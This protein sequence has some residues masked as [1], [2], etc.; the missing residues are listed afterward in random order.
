[1]KMHG[2]IIS[3]PKPEVIVIPKGGVD[4]VFKAAAILDYAEFDK[5][6]PVPN[7]PEIVRP[8]GQK[9]IDLEDKT[10]NNQ[11]TAW[12]VKKNA[13]MV[14]TSL[15][16]TEGL[17]WETV[18]AGDPETWPN[19]LTELRKVFTDAENDAIYRTVLT[20]CGLDD[21]KIKEATDR[22][23]AGQAEASVK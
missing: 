12:A 8:G 3:C 17:E 18:K 9:S 21:R 5:L 14:I 7:P 15:A 2:K 23:L 10:Y 20:A 11:L 4:Y 16:A 1:M 22:F 6:C 13:W 19:Y